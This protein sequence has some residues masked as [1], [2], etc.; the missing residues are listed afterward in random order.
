MNFQRENSKSM[1][2][3][4]STQKYSVKYI[5]Y[6]F[7]LLNDFICPSAP[8]HINIFLKGTNKINKKKENIVFQY[9]GT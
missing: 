4:S 6:F 3:K 5:V 8:K 7:S 9:L 2:Q 1:L